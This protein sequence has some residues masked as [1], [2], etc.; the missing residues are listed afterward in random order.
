MLRDLLR[1]VARG[2]AVR[3]TELASALGVSTVLVESML[4]VLAQRGYLRLVA[5]GCSACAR[6]PARA[7]CLFGNAARVWVPTERARKSSGSARA[8]EPGLT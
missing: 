5:A 2:D 4:E 7:A 6:C 1:L 8:A 3:S